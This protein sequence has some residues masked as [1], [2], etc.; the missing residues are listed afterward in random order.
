MKKRLFS[1]I[2]TLT[3]LATGFV[4]CSSKDSSSTSSTKGGKQKVYLITMDKMDQHWV[5]VDKGAK[6]MSTALGLTYKWDAPDVKDNAKQIECVNNAVADGADLILLAANDPVAISESVK[7]AKDKGVKIIY[8]DS[9]ANEPAI[10]TLSTDNYNAG[11]LAAQTMLDELKAAGIT[12]GKIGIIGVNTATNSTMNRENGFREV[13]TAAGGFT[14]LTT[15]YKDGNAAASQEAAAGFITANSDLV[16]LYGTNEGSTVGV[17]NAIKAAS[18]KKIIGIGFDKS[19]AIEGLI[20]DGSLKAA[21]VQNPYTMGYL[22]V[23]QSYAALNGLSTGPAIIDT[24]V[25]VLRK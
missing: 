23:A 3:V 17:G 13:I 15:E 5:S 14:L 12:S 7:N 6:D 25:A 18:G 20:N 1:A 9:S 16:G 21:M 19:S 11:K 22:G 4:G 10:A 2:L 24:G 8:V